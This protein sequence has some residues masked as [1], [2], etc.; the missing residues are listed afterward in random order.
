MLM[1]TRQSSISITRIDTPISAR[2]TPPDQAALSTGRDRSHESFGADAS[3]DG[4]SNRRLGS[5]HTGS[6]P[7]TDVHPELRRIARI[8]PRHIV[9]PRTLPIVR[10]LEG[11]RVRL[12]RPSASGDV[13]VVTRGSGGGVRLFRP[14][15]VTEPAPALLWIHGGGYVIGT[16]QQDDPLCRGFS[17]R[18]DITVASV[19]YR[20]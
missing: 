15:G 4:H 18:L 19:D 8:A 13:E 5:R 1:F 16:A 12:R 17:A 20:L 9:G 2:L 6:G 11:L 10:A 3:P 14:I 7:N